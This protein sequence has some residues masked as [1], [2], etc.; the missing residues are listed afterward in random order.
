MKKF[1]LGVALASQV[2][3]ALIFGSAEATADSPY[4]LVYTRQPRVAEQFANWQRWYDGGIPDRFT[5][6]DLVLD[7]QRGNITQIHNC[8]T[9][10][11]ITVSV[12]VAV[13]C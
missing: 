7:D 4:S 5:E 10:K 6:S 8:T 2:A 9:N 12:T 11:A 3:A 1:V 13:P